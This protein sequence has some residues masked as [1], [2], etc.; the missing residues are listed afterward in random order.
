MTTAD[1]FESISVGDRAEVRH[2]IGPADLNTFAAL[3]GDD[4]PLHMDEA[5]AAATS[6]G[7]RVV[8]GM[9]TA[10]FIS[11]IIG[12]RLPGP[13]ALWFEQSLRFLAP[14]RIGEAILVTAEVLHKSPATR[15]LTIR[16][17]VSG[18]GGREL[19][20]GEAK[21]KVV[22][23]E[24]TRQPEQDPGR[25]GD[26]VVITGASRG[27]GAAIAGALAAAGR[28]VVINYRTRAED[29]ERIAHAIRDAGGTAEP[30][31]ADVS[32]PDQVAAMFDQARR[33]V[34]EPLGVVNNAS[35]R[36]TP[37]PVTDLAWHEVQHQIDVQVR[38]AFEV[39]RAALPA[40]LAAGRGR[41]VNIT[42]QVVDGVPPAQWAGYTAAKAALV[43]LTRSMALELGPRGVR[44]N[45]VSPGMTPTDL[46]ADLPERARMVAKMQTPT[47]RLARPDDIA[48]VVAFLMSDA[49]DHIT[50]QTVRVGGGAVMA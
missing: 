49:A 24:Q 26:A 35:P 7:H 36:I 45:A 42:S 40:M 20:D 22:E 1:R 28:P 27:I 10:S 12:T 50:G 11:T 14:A 43:S 33:T 8:H 46:T 16:T 3:T 39:S 48:G 5:F 2:T 21:V 29:A 38:G 30:I 41:I 25:A 9:L 13:G 15:V 17:R 47:R 4:N 6:M 34:G 19:V 44:V 37:T 32:D 18:E 23:T 31:R